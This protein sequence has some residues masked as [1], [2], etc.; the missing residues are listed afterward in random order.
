MGFEDYDDSSAGDTR[1]G[2]A[3]NEA[4]WEILE[5]AEFPLTYTDASTTA[6]ITLTRPKKIHQVVDA[7]RDVVLW[8]I[9]R[10]TLQEMYPDLPDTG[11]PEYWYMDSE[12]QLRVYPAN[13]TNTIKVRYTSYP[14]EMSSTDAF[15]VPQR[16]IAAVLHRAAAKLH[17]YKQ[18]YEASAFEEAEAQRV[19]HLMQMSLLTRAAD[20]PDSISAVRE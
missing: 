1:V 19:V 9:D 18:N 6:P 10:R 11:D 12:T 14:A 15:T 20:R 17:R 2:R 8:S 4:Q 5:E 16:F 3:L 7:T 13:T